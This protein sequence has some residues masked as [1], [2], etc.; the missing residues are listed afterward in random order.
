MVQIY[1]ILKYIKKEIEKKNI[2][3]LLEQQ[4]VQP[5]RNLAQRF[6]LGR[7]NRYFRHRHTIKQYKNIMDVKFIKSHQCYLEVS[8]AFSIMYKF[9]H[10]SLPLILQYT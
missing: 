9:I 7:R 4:K 1:T 5:P 2:Q 3:F 8:Q 10:F 6:N